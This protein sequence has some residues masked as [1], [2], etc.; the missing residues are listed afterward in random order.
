MSGASAVDQRPTLRVAAFRTAVVVAVAVAVQVGVAAAIAAL[1]ATARA[2]FEGVGIGFGMCAG[3]LGAHHDHECP[4]PTEAQ[5]KEIA[6]QEQAAYS[7]TFSRVFHSELRTLA[8]ITALVL[9]VLIVY[10]MWRL[11]RVDDT[12]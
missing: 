5:Q 3:L 11:W 8:F 1:L 12:S 2:M 7:E 9:S 10:F 6:A 4:P